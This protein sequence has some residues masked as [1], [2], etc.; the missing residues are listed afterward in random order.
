[1]KHKRIILF[2]FV[3][4]LA[5]VYKLNNYQ[6]II[7][8]VEDDNA[9]YV[10]GSFIV[11]IEEKHF[12]DKHIHGFLIPGKVVDYKYDD[13]HVI[14]HQVYD[15]LYTDKFYGLSENDTLSMNE[16][17]KD[18]INAKIDIYRKMKDCY[19]IVFNKEKLIIGPLSK[20]DFDAKCKE[21]GI[22]LEF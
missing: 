14:V 10:D 1:M 6:K 21:E 7:V 5:F 11:R 22:K 3:L 8:G 20:R 9:E 15:K 16:H 4:L 18:S 13:D 19:W 12:N 2:G 17:I